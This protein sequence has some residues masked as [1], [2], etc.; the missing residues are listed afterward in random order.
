[1]GRRLRHKTRDTTDC[2]GRSVPSGEEEERRDPGAGGTLQTPIGARKRT[3]PEGD[4]ADSIGA[5]KQVTDNG[6]KADLDDQA[7]AKTLSWQ[8]RLALEALFKCL[9]ES[10]PAAHRE[11]YFG[12]DVKESM[13]RMSIDIEITR[14]HRKECLKL[15]G[16]MAVTDNGTAGPSMHD[17]VKG[18]VG[19]HPDPIEAHK[20]QVTDNETA[21]PSRHDQ[22]KGN[23]GTHLDLIEAP[24][25]QDAQQQLPLE[26]ECKASQQDGSEIR[27]HGTI[28]ALE[29][30][31]EQCPLCYRQMFPTETGMCDA[32]R[33]FCCVMCIDPCDLCR[34]RGVD[35]WL[36]L[37][38]YP[39][40]Y[41]GPVAGN[42]SDSVHRITGP[43][44]DTAF[45][46]DNGTKANEKME[47]LKIRMKLE[48]L[49]KRLQASYPAARREDYFIYDEAVERMN[50]DM[51]CVPA[52]GIA[53]TDNGTAGPSRR[54]QEKE[55]S[56]ICAGR[57]ALSEKHEGVD[58][59]EEERR[60]WGRRSWRG[61]GSFGAHKDPIGEQVTDNGT[62][63]NLESLSD[64]ADPEH[65]SDNEL[66]RMLQASRSQR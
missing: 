39:V 63:A 59:G 1:M 46:T 3:A 58:P 23:A 66:R 61:C 38:C 19:T 7:D 31:A 24:K 54:D 57:S 21:G 32:C 20:K 8:I 2:V 53:V 42:T 9:Q 34:Y 35:S 43:L 13:E 47:R 56:T 41:C 28:A 33:R 64:D 44:A 29:H 27:K 49:F 12:D 11:D 22:G 52:E 6:T 50:M 65:L 30:R 60:D 51:E 16:G 25:T 40:H 10:Y 17:Q 26:D 15:A 14:A 48:A 5:K 55:N 45:V 36:C 62:N 18:N 37:D 4:L